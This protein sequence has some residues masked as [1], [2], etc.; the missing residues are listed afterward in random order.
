MMVVCISIRQYCRVDYNT[1]KIQL[2]TM[3]S[4]WLDDYLVW[5]GV[6]HD[7]P[8][9]DAGE[10]RHLQT[11][12]AIDDH[13]VAFIWNSDEIGTMFKS[14][15]TDWNPSH[16]HRVIIDGI[17]YTEGTLNGTDIFKWFKER[18]LANS[19][20]YSF[21]PHIDDSTT[22]ATTFEFKDARIAMLFK[23]TFGGT[24]VQSLI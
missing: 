23:L 24:H 10:V 3:V 14:Y 11:W 9:A 1:L 7:W 22:L 17:R 8:D 13:W 19:G 16:K 15:F 5:E 21:A 2:G 6:D 20:D 18:D 4:G 12:V